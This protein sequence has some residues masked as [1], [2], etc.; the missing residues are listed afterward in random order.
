MRLSSLFVALGGILS[1]NLASAAT[2]DAIKSA[3]QDKTGLIADT[4]SPSPVKGFWEGSIGENILYIS[5]DARFIFTGTLLN[6]DTR[7]NLTQ[8]S[9]KRLAKDRWK[10]W[11]LKDAVKQVFG[12]GERQLVVFSDANCTYCRQMEKVYANVN[13]LTVYTFIMPMLQ[14]SANAD[15]I[16]CAKDQAKA[17]HDWMLRHQ[18]PG[19][20][21]AGCDTSVLQRNME[22]AVRNNV[23]GAPTMFFPNGTRLNG[24][25][26]AE[27]LESVFAMP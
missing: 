13:N 21:L 14:G 22:L 4:V 23:R 3:L 20:V 26:S 27:Q 17:W 16:V 12:N 9:M 11:P 7:E 6:A 8:R 1:L 18:R 15:Q 25:I 5:D 24:A 19:S 10:H 2:A